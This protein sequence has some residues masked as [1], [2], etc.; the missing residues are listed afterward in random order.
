MVR[1]IQGAKINPKSSFKN[2]GVQNTRGRKLRE[3]IRHY[4]PAL[5]RK[6]AN[7]SQA[8]GERLSYL[9]EQL[10]ELYVSQSEKNLKVAKL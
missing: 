7:I 10:F 8:L 2:L 5:K 6:W 1:E 3:Q 4:G 9:D